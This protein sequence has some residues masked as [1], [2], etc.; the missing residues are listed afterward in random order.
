MSETSDMW[1][2][3][4]YRVNDHVL[5]HAEDKFS[6]GSVCG[7]FERHCA[8]YAG[9]RE[10]LTALVPG[11]G[12]AQQTRDGSPW[13]VRWYMAR[14]DPGFSWGTTRTRS[15]GSLTPEEIDRILALAEMVGGA[16]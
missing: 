7:Q 13:G 11:V 12:M 16:P 5:T 1:D 2:Q 6:P 9:L 4:F 3:F 10:A 14:V 15:R 8:G